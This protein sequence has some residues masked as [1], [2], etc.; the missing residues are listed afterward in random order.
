MV[1]DERRMEL[2]FEAQRPFD[3]IRN[4]RNISHKFAGVQPWKE[5]PYDCDE[6]LFAIPADEI[7][8]SG[9]P[10]NPGKGTNK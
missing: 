8:V 9:I 10:Q 4:K 3:L 1:L 5:Y 6:F 7:L 2:C